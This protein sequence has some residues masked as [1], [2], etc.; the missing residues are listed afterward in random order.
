MS[1]PSQPQSS[2]IILKEFQLH[3]TF[4]TQAQFKCTWWFSSYYWVCQC[5]RT[6]HIV[7]LHIALTH[8]LWPNR[9]NMLK[10]IKKICKIMQKN[11]KNM[12]K[13]AVYVGSIFCLYSNGQG[14][15]SLLSDAS[16]RTWKVTIHGLTSTEQRW[17]GFSRPH[18]R[19]SYC[20]L[21]TSRLIAVTSQAG[22]RASRTIS[23]SR[24]TAE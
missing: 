24:S 19:Y 5:S 2:K 18:V 16:V 23:E 13:Y 22:P 20:R 14:T 9:Q 11:W 21:H 4:R 17:E 1:C 6:C 7:T 15:S 8:W 12:P 10:D 3:L